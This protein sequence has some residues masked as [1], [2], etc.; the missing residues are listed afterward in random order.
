MSTEHKAPWEQ[1]TDPNYFRKVLGNFV[2]LG[3][4][5]RRSEV[6]H[7]RFGQ[8]GVGH[9]PNYQIECPDG[10]KHC[11]RGM[12]H[13]EAPDVKEEFAPNNLSER[14]YTYHDVE[15]MLARLVGQ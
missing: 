8:T 7:V 5:P 13:A 1:V 9:A 11:F 15:A 3:C 12:G 14:S 2:A 4:G 10:K 6:A